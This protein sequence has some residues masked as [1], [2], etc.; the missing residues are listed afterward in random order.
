MA[1]STWS[2]AW[3]HTGS[4]QPVDGEELAMVVIRAVTDWESAPQL[5]LHRVSLST[6]KQV[7]DP[8]VGG[9]ELIRQ[10]E[11]ADRGGDHR[12]EL[13]QTTQLYSG[14]PNPFNPATTLSFD[15]HEPGPVRLSIYDTLGR[16]IATLI[17]HRLDA[18]RHKLTWDAAHMASGMYLVRLETGHTAQTRQ[19]MLLK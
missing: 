17:D 13:P 18:G 16:R 12:D 14:Y 8:D 9:W 2:A 11:P 10:I 6:H 19:V 4:V 5:R 7:M 3:V 1:G 15:L